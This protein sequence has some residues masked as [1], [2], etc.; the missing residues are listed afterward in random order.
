MNNMKAITTKDKFSEI[1]INKS[2]IINIDN[3]NDKSKKKK[4][5]NID[6]VKLYSKLFWG[7]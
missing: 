3:G 7:S 1:D 5:N 4:D 2:L 6:K